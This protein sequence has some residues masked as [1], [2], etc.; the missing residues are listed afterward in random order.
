METEGA[1]ASHA[2][3]TIKIRVQARALI[4]SR[5]DN[6]S[7]YEDERR[8]VMNAKIKNALDA[9]GKYMDDH[10]FEMILRSLFTGSTLMLTAYRLREMYKTG[11]TYYQQAEAKNA[12]EQSEKTTDNAN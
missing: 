4:L 8:C 1:A 2:Q 5:E 3:V 9:A 7:L 12:L 10:Q 11:K 6:I